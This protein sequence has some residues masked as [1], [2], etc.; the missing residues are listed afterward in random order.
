MIRI[1]IGGRFS[2]VKWIDASAG[3]QV[4]QEPRPGNLA[5]SQAQEVFA[6]DLAIDQFHRFLLQPFHQGGQG[7]LRGVGLVM[8]HGFPAKATSHA[9]AVDASDQPI[10]FPGFHAV[11]DA[12]LVETDVRLLHFRSDP[13]SVLMG[14]RNLAQAR[15]TWANAVS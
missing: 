6:G 9:H 11:R 4:S 7:H 8:E 15:I 1:T 2:K 10:T 12:K 14:P 5:G 3:M 13:R